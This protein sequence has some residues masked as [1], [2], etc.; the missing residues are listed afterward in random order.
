VWL[1]SS[2][3]QIDGAT[4]ASILGGSSA[5]AAAA[6]KLPGG[7][8]GSSGVAAA[9]SRLFGGSSGSSGSNGSLMYQVV[10][11]SAGRVLGLSPCSPAAAAVVWELPL[12][13]D[14]KGDALAKAQERYVMFV[15]GVCGPFDGAVDFGTA[16]PRSRPAVEAVLQPRGVCAFNMLPH[17]FIV[18]ILWCCCRRASA[19][20]TAFNPS[21]K[22]AK[23][24]PGSSRD[25]ISYS[26]VQ[27]QAVPQEGVA[28]L[29]LLLQ[30]R[31]TSAAVAAAEA[32][33]ASPQQ[34]Q[35]QQLPAGVVMVGSGKASSPLWLMRAVV[36]P[37]S[38]D[39][40]LSVWAS[41]GAMFQQQQQQQHQQ[42]DLAAG[43][44][45]GMGSSTAA[46]AGAGAQE[47]GGAVSLTVDG[48]EVQSMEAFVQQLIALSQQAQQQQQQQ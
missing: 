10:A 40:S 13:V 47:A 44:G 27:Q 38:D 1:S 31:A 45:T 16:K 11:D 36:T 15:F 39:D 3:A 20:A 14:L 29:K 41:R 9:A 5:A 6:S 42:R 25:K 35:Q 30:P 8:S 34:Q 26:P 43:S 2:E 17:D 28:V 19:V 37:W 18:C 12:A 33:A 23:K 4:A 48:Q 24:P 21:A 46:A 7:S 32:T 22:P